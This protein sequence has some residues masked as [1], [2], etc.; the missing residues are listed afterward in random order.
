MKLG[1][2]FQEFD[3]LADIPYAVQ[4]M[5]DVVLQWAVQGKLVPQSSKDEP[6]CNLIQNAVSARKQLVGAGVVRDESRDLRFL[7]RQDTGLPKGWLAV[8]LSI[9]VGVIMG[10]SPPSS[11]YNESGKGLPFYQG[12]AQFGRLYPTATTW[13]TEPTKIGEPQD[14]IISV[15]APVGPTNMLR[16]SSCIGRGLAALRSLGGDQMHLLYTLRAFERSIAALG[17]GSTFVAV[18]KRDLDDFVVPVPP[19]AE[20]RRIVAKVDQLMALVD[21]L[22]KQIVASRITAGNLLSALVAELTSMGSGFQALQSPA[23]P[24]P[25]GPATATNVFS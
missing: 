24:A 13:C 7:E 1:A 5:R 11:A 16:E 23:A 12:K 20:Q 17:V 6:A 19:L 21:E 10:Q 15:R 8:P 4:K 18:S 14:V 22:E 9:Y 2:F 3:R 25:T